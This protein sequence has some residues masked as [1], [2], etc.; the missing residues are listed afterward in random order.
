MIAK[1]NV[2]IKNKMV[3]NIEIMDGGFITYKTSSPA[4]DLISYLAGIRQIWK[5]TGQKAIIYQLLNIVGE[6]IYGFPQPFKNAKGE[7]ILMGKE[8]FDNLKPLIEAQEY[9]EKYI[10]YKGG[11]VHIDL[12]KLRGEIFTNQ[13]LGSLAKYPSYGF[14]Q[15]ACDLSEIVLN[16]PVKKI[17]D[18]YNIE[19]G[20]EKYIPVDGFENYVVINFTNRYRNNFINY[21]FLKQY[22]NRIIFCGLNDEYD[23]FC[24]KWD[25]EIPLLKV[26]NFLELGQAINNCKFFLSNASMCF[27]IAEALKVPRILEIYKHLPNVIPVGKDAYDV[28]NQSAIEFYFDKLIN[29]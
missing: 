2:R 16:I 11:N 27:Q 29:R 6:G 7:S 8:M 3:E 17:T 23:F 26:L 4:G 5:E 24:K 13:P 9:V 14:P 22:E 20:G 19:W 18:N 10:E 25:L 12:D 28:H 15:M 1:V 21:F